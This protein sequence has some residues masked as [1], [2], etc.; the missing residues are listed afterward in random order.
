MES[1][2]RFSSYFSSSHNPENTL[3]RLIKLFISIL[4]FPV[5]YL[6]NLTVFFFICAYLVLGEG[7]RCFFHF[8]QPGCKQC[9][10]SALQAKER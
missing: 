4:V 1:I 10:L 7:E 2:L 8:G 5:V 9:S 3:F 6:G